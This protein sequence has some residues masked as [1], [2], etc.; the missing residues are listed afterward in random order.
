MPRSEGVSLV[1]QTIKILPAM[2]E[3]WVKSLGQEDPLQKGMQPTPVFLPGELQ[4][5]SGIA[6]YSPWDPKELGATERLYGNSIFK[7]LRNL[8]NVFHI[9]CTD[10]HS[11]QHCTRILFL[12]IL[13][14]NCY[15]LLF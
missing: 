1:S 9:G 8:H 5:Q 11:H 12:H 3:T 7:V 15:L 6:G 14:K 13:T 2:Q 10:L 4:G